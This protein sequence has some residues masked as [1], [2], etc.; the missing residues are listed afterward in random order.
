MKE[1]REG[2]ST[3]S[4]MT[5][6]AEASVIWQ[7]TGKCPSV[8]K[9]ETP[10]GKT[11]YLDI[12]PKEFGVCGVVKDAGDDPDVTNGSEIITK[13]ELF[14]EEGDISFFG[15]DGVGTITQE[16]LKIPPGQP[17]I[18]P[19][20]RQMAEKA[21]RKIIGNKKANI[22]VSIPG[23]E[24][25]AKKTF[26]PRLGIVNGLSILGTT[27]I[28]RPMSEEAMKDSLIAELDMYAKQGHKSI[29]FVLGGT[30]ETVLKEQYGEFQCILQVSNYIGFMIEEAVERG[31]FDWWVCRKACKSSIRYNEYTQSCGRWP[32]R[33]NLYTCSSSWRPPFSHTKAV[34]LPYNK[35]GNEDCGRRGTYGYLAGYGTKSV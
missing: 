33:N 23:G 10:I 26:N 12:I 4:C 15:G 35:G 3:G 18:N 1:L 7:T 24:E 17:A 29:L 16:G 8:V 19:V 2:V 27:G 34:F 25:L 11:L 30:G 6:G 22:T 14:E 5:G 28:V 21:I 13:V 32:Y 20:P 31:Y 9:V